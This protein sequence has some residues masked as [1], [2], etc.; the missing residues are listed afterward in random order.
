MAG[1]RPYSRIKSPQTT[2]VRISRVRSS[3]RSHQAHKPQSYDSLKLQPTHPPTEA[4]G[5]AKKA[6][7]KLFESDLRVE[8]C[9]AEM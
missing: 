1:A 6:S 9:N 8:S 2:K 7:G 5:T 3:Y 4:T